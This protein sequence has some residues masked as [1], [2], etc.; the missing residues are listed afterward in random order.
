MGEDLS[1]KS[2]C[3]RDDWCKLDAGLDVNAPTA[4]VKSISAPVN[5]PSADDAPRNERGLDASASS[6]DVKS[7]SASVN[8]PSADDSHQSSNHGP[9]F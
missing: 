8:A 2:I 6:T 7:A 1:S 4:D 9:H 5:V 3:G